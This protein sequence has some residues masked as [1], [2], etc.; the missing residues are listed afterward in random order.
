MKTEKGNRG[1][2]VNC[3]AV[4]AILLIAWTVTG[5]AKK[6]ADAQTEKQI[7]IRIGATGWN[8]FES[9]L[10]A[11]GLDNTYY[12]A[13]YYVFQGGNLCLEAMAAGQLDFTA[14]S[15]IPPVAASFAENGGNFKIIAVNNSSP[16]T[17][18]V[19]ALKDSGI[20]T[21]AD[22][23][24]KKV[25]YIKNT[26]AQYF[27]FQMLKEAGLDW[28][29][30]DAIAITTADG[31][32]ALRSGSIDAF[33]S[34][35]NSINAAK[36]SGAVTVQTALTIL[37]GNFPYEISNK[38]LADP[39]KKAAI[40]DYLARIQKADEWQAQN[41]EKWAAI[42]ADPT[43]QSYD[44]CLTLLKNTYADHGPVVKLPD[45]QIVQSEQKV[46][47]AF[48]ELGLFKS[49]A[50]VSKFY[51]YSLTDLYNKALNKLK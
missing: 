16:Q 32:T 48:Y 3:I 40:A 31:V 50:D 45:A 6:S 51:D 36:N 29:D 23:K 38:A 43:G 26:T 25:G 41:I 17:Q 22:L 30:I 34:Y 35:G 7:T 42:Q 2:T 28:K 21:I 39:E 10:K 33:A 27:L 5:C 15:E 44:D 47:D 4:F 20:K 37:S 8:S 19:V 11:A 24:G 49:K 18:E 13:E 12:K 9:S 14:T 46:A 1:F